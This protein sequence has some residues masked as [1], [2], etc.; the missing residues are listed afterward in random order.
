MTETTP[1][2]ACKP[3]RGLGAYP[4]TFLSPPLL[5]TQESAQDSQ[6]HGLFS[7]KDS[8]IFASQHL[9]FGLNMASSQR[10]SLAIFGKRRDSITITQVFPN[11]YQYLRLSDSSGCTLVSVRL[12]PQEYELRRGSS[13]FCLAHHCSPTSK[14]SMWCGMQ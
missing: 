9:G 7:L 1:Q 11:I 8:Q 3:V 14:N 10:P 4:R 6:T 5:F 12:S 13:L 2:L